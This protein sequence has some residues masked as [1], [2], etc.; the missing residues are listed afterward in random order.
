[1]KRMRV[2]AVTPLG[3]VKL[4]YMMVFAAYATTVIYRTIYYRRVGLDTGQIGVLIA[5]QPLLMLVAGP[6]WSAIADRLGIRSRLLTLV[7]GLSIVPMVAMA[8][9]QSFVGLF[10]L[11]VLHALLQTT[12]EP[13]MNA[14]AWST[15][16]KE[17][18]QF[19]IIRGWG[20][21]GYAPVAWL[22]GILLE[23]IDIRWISG[24]YALLMGISALISLT[25]AGERVT[26][27]RP[28]LGQGLGQIL[29]QR[30]WLIFVSAYFAVM[31]LG[32]IT[33]SYLGIYLDTLGSSEGLIGF[34]GAIGSFGQ[35][36]LMMTLLPWLLRRWSAQRMILLAFGVYV[37]RFAIWT[38][39]PIPAVVGGAEIL[40]G[41][42][43]GS[44][45]V[46]GVDFAA[47]HA[48]KGLEATSQAL[49]T[50]L[51]SGLGRA[52]VT[53]A[54]GVL[55]EQSG[56]A[57]TFGIALVVASLCLLAYG[58]IWRGGRETQ[59]DL[60]VEPIP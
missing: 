23:T 28:R 43:F 3:R 24:A 33:F 22:M 45:Y 41:L 50:S 35:T 58:F 27:L 48:P 1:V 7:M 52:T 18:H 60:Q 32:S 38:F 30:S 42:A 56:P 53:L 46:A 10:V 55:F 54:T 14:T 17:R 19:S 6:I 26:L 36:L 37:L 51:A 31:G 11:S 8:F 59:V 15:I 44:A 16:E 2:R 13:L 29:R 12:I 20:S 9:V 49:V 25:F 40:L 21:L 34:A 39:I 5:L 47:R 4:L 57:M